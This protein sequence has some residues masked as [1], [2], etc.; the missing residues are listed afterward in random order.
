MEIPPQGL[1]VRIMPF[2]GLAPSSSITS[3]PSQPPSQTSGMKQISNARPWFIDFEDGTTLK[4][5]NENLKIY[6]GPS[7][8]S[9]SR[10][11]KS[12]LPPDGFPMSNES[13]GKYVDTADIKG[14]SSSRKRKR[15][16]RRKS[17]RVKTIRNRMN[18]RTARL[19]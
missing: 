10:S 2:D 13:V 15:S 1:V 19:H 3:S 16:Q 14:G 6:D 4:N 8:T 17:K 11:W 5:P 9:F 18:R 7:N 12:Y